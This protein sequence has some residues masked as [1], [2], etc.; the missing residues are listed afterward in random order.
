MLKKRSPVYVNNLKAP[1]GPFGPEGSTKNFGFDWPWQW[2]NR[3]CLNI[4]NG[5]NDGSG[6]LT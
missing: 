3:R 4:V 6:E 5:N 2:F 1:N